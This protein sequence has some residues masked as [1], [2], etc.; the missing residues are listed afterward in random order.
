MRESAGK[1]GILMLLGNNPYPQDPRVR[2]EATALEEAGYRVTVICPRVRGQSA[3]E[4]V[5][6]VHVLRYRQRVDA[7]GMAGY[8]VE[9]GVT[10][11]AA[12]LLSV[13]V[14]FGRGFDVIHAHNPPDTFVL[15]AALYKMLG[16]RFVF[17][18]HDLAPEMY[19]ARF[20]GRG[21]RFARFGLT[22]LERCSCRLADRVVA[23]NESYKA[24]EIQRGKVPPERIAVV[25]NGSG[26]E[27]AGPLDPDPTLRARAS[28]II[29]YLGVMGVQDGVDHLLRAVRHL[30]FD[31][32]REDT[33]CVLIG[34][35]DAREDL[36]RLARELRIDDHV[37]FTGFI[38]AEEVARYLSTV[39]VCVVP[40]PSNHFNDRST[41][42]KV[43]DYMTFA[44]P[45]VAFDLPE[46]RITAGEA[47]SYVRPNDDFE[48]A[49]RIAA[50][51]DDP[52]RR[53]EMGACGRNRVLV[54]L[55]WERSVPNLLALYR[56]L[57]PADGTRS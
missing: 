19:E 8:L 55:G 25:R 43:M 40:D 7:R 27:G 50:L 46:T 1:G 18:H 32:G 38:P 10:T 57:L 20:G 45:I 53:A 17:D 5:R 15:V 29:G 11:A 2:R 21:N 30:V 9:Y 39:D 36:Q 22:V 49:T 16:K 31:L 51:M 48:L 35:G 42:I 52:T 47:A 56:S 14:M 12:L 34:R 23:T 3:R 4:T 28:S 44:R 24:V 6:G 13:R 33:L 54:E 37:W 26:F 41:M